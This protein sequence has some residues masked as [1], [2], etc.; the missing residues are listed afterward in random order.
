MKSP[1]FTLLLTTILLL[2]SATLL[3]G[4]P[5]PQ[6]KGHGYFKLSEWWVRFDQHFTDSG[7]LDPNV[8]TGVYNT[9]LYAEYGLTDRLTG[10][11][12][13]PFFSRNTMNNLISQTNGEVIAPGEAINGLGD[14]EIAFRYAINQSGAS[15]PMAVSL[16]LGLPLGEDRGGS[17]GNLQ[18]GD[19]EFNQML[20]VHGGKSFQLG[21]RNA[22]WSSY[23]G[24]NNRTEGFSDEFRYGAEVGFPLAQ[25]KLWVIGRLQGVASFRNGDTAENTTNTSIFAN[26]AEYLSPGIEINYYLNDRLGFS[27]GAAGA[28]YGRVIAAAPGFSAGVFLDLS[29]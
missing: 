3:A 14:T 1:L 11:I 29:K 16:T 13:F 25:N 21:E 9:T 5:W 2:S 26:N 10:V 28:V 18:L 20:L 23:L 19:G 17:Q 27:V 24:F 8:T 6:K 4:G 15:F 12:N 7:K 22:Y